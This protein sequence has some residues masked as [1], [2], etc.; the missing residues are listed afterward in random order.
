MFKKVKCKYLNSIVEAIVLATFD[1]EEFE[2]YNKNNF[3]FFKKQKSKKIVTK[4]AIIFIPY[5]HQ[6]KELKLISFDDVLDNDFNKNNF[7]ENDT[8]FTKY[9]YTDNNYFEYKILNFYGYHFICQDKSFIA[10]IYNNENFKCLENVYK[11]LPT[12]INEIFDE[13][14]NLN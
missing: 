6:L 4:K 8:F 5:K 11:N 2:Y 12:I 9:Y 1:I 7:V 13:E 10:N 3:L 14:F